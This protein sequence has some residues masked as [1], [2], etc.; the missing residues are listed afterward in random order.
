MARPMLDHG[1][2]LDQVTEIWEV[3]MPK[4]LSDPKVAHKL[5]EIKE[6]LQEL[7][8]TCDRSI[9]EA[10]HILLGAGIRP[11]DVNSPQIYEAQHV[12]AS[13][14]TLLLI[15]DGQ[16]TWHLQDKPKLKPVE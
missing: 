1:H 4:G 12:K 2:N 13:V 15:L 6:E 11:D 10:K 5:G 16:Y 8:K 9:E 3:R 7:V 14:H